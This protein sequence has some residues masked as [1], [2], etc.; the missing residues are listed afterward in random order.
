ML[1]RMLADLVLQEPMR[2]AVAQR[3]VATTPVVEHLDVLEQISLRVG[4]RRVGRPMHPLVL[5][6]VEEALGG[7]VDA[8]MSSSA[9]QI[10]QVGKD[11]GVQLPHQVALEASVD[12]F[13]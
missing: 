11:V 13:V 9:P 2:R 7:C 10:C 4:S 5:Q 1:M 12:L 3:G 6:A 8:P